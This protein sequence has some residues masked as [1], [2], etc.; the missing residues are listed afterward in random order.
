MSEVQQ[1][2]S[3]RL[4]ILGVTST[5]NW[6]EVSSHYRGPETPQDTAVQTIGPD[7]LQLGFWYGASGEQR[8]DKFDKD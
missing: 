8:L 5:W 3:A 2:F 6:C 1:L 7:L 4:D